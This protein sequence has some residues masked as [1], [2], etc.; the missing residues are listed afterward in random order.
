PIYSR[1]RQQVEG[2]ALVRRIV[3]DA[4]RRA[5]RQVLDAVDRLRV[6][7]E[8]LDVDALEV[9]EVVDLSLDLRLEVREVLEVVRVQVAVDQRLVGR[10]VV[11]ELLDREVESGI[12]REVL[13]DEAEDVAVRHGRDAHGERRDAVG[14]GA[15]RLLV[16]AAGP[17]GRERE[18]ARG[19][20]GSE[21][22]G[23]AH[24][25][26][27]GGEARTGMVRGAG[28]HRRWSTERAS[29]SPSSWMSATHATSRTMQAIIV[30]VW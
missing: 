12:R 30:S 7:R 9:G 29:R 27:W 20:R 17:A 24:D 1:L 15:D 11:G 18:D 14:L 28:G 16:S 13:V 5:V 3:V 21:G 4:D 8:G 19:D 23:C 6:E 26:P 22:E 2:T 25:S 10:G